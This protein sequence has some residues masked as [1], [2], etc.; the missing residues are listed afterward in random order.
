MYGFDAWTATM[1][2]N[3]GNLLL[4]GDGFWLID[5]AYSFTGPNWQANELNPSRAYGNSHERWLTN[6]LPIEERGKLVEPA[7][8]LPSR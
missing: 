6:E 4:S 7:R 3:V 5:H 2:R 1:D 8:L